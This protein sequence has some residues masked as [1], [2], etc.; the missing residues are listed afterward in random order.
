MK[1]NN[2]NS[3]VTKKALMNAFKDVHALKFDRNQ[4]INDILNSFYDV[5]R[6]H[7]IKQS[8][9]NYDKDGKIV[10]RLMCTPEWVICHNTFMKKFEFFLVIEDL[11]EVPKD[12]Q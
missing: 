3:R 9:P 2:S 5:M 11:K 10:S 6:K 1:E 12:V 4:T 7:G 8:T